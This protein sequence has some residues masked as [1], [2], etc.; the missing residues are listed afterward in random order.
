MTLGKTKAP[1]IRSMRDRDGWKLFWMCIPF[2]IFIFIFAYLPLWG[3][4]LRLCELSPRPFTVQLR[5]CRL[6]ELR[7]SLRPSR[8]AQ[9]PF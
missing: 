1:S 2:M 8:D 6:G 4:V 3:L 5:L 7:D 9:P